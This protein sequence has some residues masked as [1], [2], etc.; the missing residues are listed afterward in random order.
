[1]EMLLTALVPLLSD[2]APLLGTSSIAKVIAA[3][4]QLIPLIVQEAT[5]LLPEVKN[6]IAALSS[7][8][9]TDADQLAQLAALD[10]Q[11]DAAFDAAA[12]A[13]Q[14]QDAAPA[15]GAS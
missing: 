13:A 9:A 15:T 14:A 10:A 3:L 12:A 1:M 6:I 5:D 11:V 2:V 4:T 7:N 8:T